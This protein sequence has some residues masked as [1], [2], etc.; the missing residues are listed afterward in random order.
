MTTENDAAGAAVRF[1]AVS[2]S[3]GRGEKRHLVLNEA[4]FDVPAGKTTVF[5]LF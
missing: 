5:H 2:K 1:V 4:S 3:F